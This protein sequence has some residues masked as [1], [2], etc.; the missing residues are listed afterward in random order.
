MSS[1][2]A[3]KPV[4]ILVPGHYMTL[5]ISSNGKVVLLDPFTNWAD[6]RRRVGEFNSLSEITN[7]YGGISWAAAYEKI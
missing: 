4:V 6:S 7:I 2:Q 1:L 5:S 3:G